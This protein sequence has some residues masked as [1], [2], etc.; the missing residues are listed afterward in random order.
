MQSSIYQ[1]K[2]C[3]DL[4]DQIKSFRQ[5]IKYQKGT[6]E[7]KV[8]SDNLVTVTDKHNSFPIIYMYLFDYLFHCSNSSTN[9][10]SIF[11]NKENH[12]VQNEKI[13]S[14]TLDIKCDVDLD[15]S[16][17]HFSGDQ[18]YIRFRIG[19]RILRWYNFSLFNNSHTVYATNLN[20]GLSEVN[21]NQVHQN[22]ELIV[23][24]NGYSTDTLSVIEI[25]NKSCGFCEI[26]S[27]KS[28]SIESLL[29]NYS[30]QQGTDLLLQV[31]NIPYKFQAL[32]DA[33]G[34]N[35]AI[36]LIGYT[37]YVLFEIMNTVNRILKN[38]S[39]S[40]IVSLVIMLL[41]LQATPYILLM[42]IRLLKRR[43]SGKNRH[44]NDNEDTF[45][46]VISLV[47]K[48]WKYIVN[49]FIIYSIYGITSS[50]NIFQKLNIND[51]TL[52]NCGK[53]LLDADNTFL[54][55]Q[56][57]FGYF[58]LLKLI[59]FIS[60]TFKQLSFM[61]KNAKV[62]DKIDMNRKILMMSIILLFIYAMRINYSFMIIIIIT[63]LFLGF[64][65]VAL[66]NITS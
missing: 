57:K 40:A 56:T 64:G 63:N 2:E 6:R 46:Y 47:I 8:H 15:K 32:M 20:G 35:V 22:K 43:N 19:E 38:D 5:N 31:K 54:F 41:M 30:G 29:V 4:S 24:L 9:L 37:P 7:C 13:L 53:S 10:F 49:L 45:S 44:I 16:T 14:N 18:S 39:N 28:G 66:N 60:L 23:F 36:R 59:F 61:S 1:D 58:S 12:T 48:N 65:D 3:L 42:L 34:T 52:L 33:Y 21:N 11:F 27:I 17:L 51:G 55:L 62:Y 50:K 26:G 25:T